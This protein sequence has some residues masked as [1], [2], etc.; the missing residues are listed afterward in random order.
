MS[1]IE[2]ILEKAEREGVIPRGVSAGPF[3]SRPPRA[4]ATDAYEAP[5]APLPRFIADRDRGDAATAE[6]ATRVMQRAAL[7]PLLIASTDGRG[8]AA[9]Q[10]KLLRTR[11]M[12]RL[13]DRT[14]HTMLVTSPGRRDGKSLT[15]ANLGLTMAQDY[16][17]RICIL[18]ADF[19]AMDQHRLFGLPAAPGLSDVLGGHAP[20]DDALVTIDEQH[21][22][23]LPAG[24]P[25]TR[26]AELL[27]TPVMRRVLDALR[28][29]FDAVII[30][31]PAAGPLADVGVLMPLVDSVLLIVRAG[32]TSTPA[33][34]EAV[35]AIDP[36]KFLGF[37]L[38]D[39]A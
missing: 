26:P 19:R 16:Q 21:I 13:D 37:V 6:P 33:I 35:T 20:L 22:T 1:R 39:T 36:A 10:Y 31:A 38:N 29:R 27:G 32:V 14:P 28:S 18:D 8:V 25:P 11:I 15:A 30:D 23:V 4:V 9:E 2:Q 7:E 34:H 3:V 12:A 24:P 17:R 5:S